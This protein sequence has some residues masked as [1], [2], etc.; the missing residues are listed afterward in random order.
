SIDA[1]AD[2]S[3]TEQHPWGRNG[4]ASPR[5]GGAPTSRPPRRWRGAALQPSEDREVDA[6]ALSHHAAS[7]GERLRADRIIHRHLRAISLRAGGARVE[8]AVRT[9]LDA[10]E[11]GVE[12]PRE[13]LGEGGWS[14][15]VRCL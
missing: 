3:M 14:R 11:P 12:V 6:A 9:D 15:V 5:I 8:A 4:R 10:T 7:V 1:A 2:G 13:L